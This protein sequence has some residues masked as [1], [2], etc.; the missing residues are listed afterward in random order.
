[1]D[2]STKNKK[3]YH[4]SELNKDIKVINFNKLKVIYMG[5]GSFGTMFSPPIELPG[6]NPVFINNNYIGKIFTMNED[7]TYGH[8][9]DYIREK[10]NQL[11]LKRIDP[12]RLASIQMVADGMFY[13]KFSKG[14]LNTDHRRFY[15]LSYQ[16][17]YPVADLLTRIDQ[18]N[19]RNETEILLMVLFFFQSFGRLN[20]QGLY[21]LD[22]T[23]SNVMY[24]K[25]KGL[26][27]AIDFG[28]STTNFR[29]YISY[30]E[31]HRKLGTP[32]TTPFE[33]RFL[34]KV[35]H[36]S[37]PN[38]KF[39]LEPILDERG[40]N[41]YFYHI[42]FTFCERYKGLFSKPG[43]IKY[44]GRKLL[45]RSTET[46]KVDTIGEGLNDEIFDK[47]KELGIEYKRTNNFGPILDF[48]ATHYFAHRYDSIGFGAFI[49]QFL[50]KYLYHHGRLHSINNVEKVILQV[51]S[52]DLIQPIVHKRLTITR[53]HDKILS[54]LSSASPTF[55][56]QY[57]GFEAYVLE[58]KQA[59]WGTMTLSNF[60]IEETADAIYRRQEVVHNFRKEY[61]D[62]EREERYQRKVAEKQRENQEQR[63]MR[64]IE[65]NQRRVNRLAQE[66][67]MARL[68]RQAQNDNNERRRGRERAVRFIGNAEE[69]R[70]CKELGR[71]PNQCRARENCR[72]VDGANRKYCR[73]RGRVM[74]PDR[75]RGYID[76]VLFP[77]RGKEE[78]QCADI[79]ICLWRPQAIG[80]KRTVRAHCRKRRGAF[81]DIF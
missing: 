69:R 34:S 2:I 70:P 37:N 81:V 18:G 42:Y 80:P 74:N 59:P 1:M 55:Y 78:T 71:E 13:K 28:L 49:L 35:I 32:G 29:K 60:M 6:I 72:Y 62:M 7:N 46:R 27:M 53:A 25:K 16:I 57:R 30:I 33:F 50:T 5:S 73:V 61:V 40:Y 23:N 51:V 22:F 3:I 43:K 48:M 12:D 26:L 67:R 10:K 21:H 20:D 39:E 44:G 38:E 4:R 75:P 68:A 15:W 8:Y 14:E 45:E 31:S 76:P 47:I 77:C 63:M 41:K 64:I 36:H 54:I 17:V 19:E 65:N 58:N 79:N 11:I 56:S 52:N 9:K 24:S 66:D